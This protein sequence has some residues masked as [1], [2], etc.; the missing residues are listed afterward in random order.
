MARRRFQQGSLALRGKRQRVWV[1]RWWEDEIQIDGNLGRIR[2]AEVIGTLAELPT[3]R[4]AMRILTER[5]GMLNSGRQRPQSSLTLERFVRENWEPVILPTLKYA[6]Q[7]HYQYMLKVHILPAFG[8]TKLRE[9]SRQ[10]IQTFLLGKL[11]QGL[12][13]ETVHHLRCGLS[14]I[15]AAAEEWGYV[16]DNLVVK[17]KL[18]RRS[19][20][21]ERPMLTAEQIRLLVSQLQEPS[22]SLVLLLTATGLRIGEL[23]ALRWG[24]IDLKAGLLRVSETVYEGHFD[25]PKTSSSVRVIPIG[26]RSVATLGALRPVVVDQDTLVFSNREGKPLDRRNLLARDIAPACKRLGLPKV[27]WHSFRHCNA[28]LLDSIGTPLGTVQALLGHSTPEITRSIYLHA[29]PEDQRRAV[30]NLERLIFGLKWT[31]VEESAEK[32]IPQFTD[33]QGEIGRGGRI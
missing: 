26:A 1:A 21:K 4:A 30:E 31:Q 23:L 25:K 9:L 28:T 2:K 18:P 16:E 12:S 8:N 5:L 20:K 14:K 11:Q 7:R 6:T 10:G 19:G 32:M 33:G 22:R 3:K 13:W 29:V 24:N 17:T 15:L 27:S